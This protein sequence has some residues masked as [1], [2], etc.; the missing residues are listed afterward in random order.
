MR[1]TGADGERRDREDDADRPAR[2]RPPTA[3]FLP[4]FIALQGAVSGACGQHDQWQAKIAAGVCAALRF[5]AEEPS[6]AHALT[7]DARRQS[8]ES[9]DREREVVDYFTTLLGEV[10]PAE[11][12]FPI[13]TDRGT[14]ESIAM[15]TRGHLLAGST[16]KLPGLSGELVYMALMPYTGLAGARRWAESLDLPAT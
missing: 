15:V 7:I 16:D 9:G 11:K 2:W 5:A 1:K 4:S 10:A 8:L 13:S 6:A 12:R 3:E 14:V